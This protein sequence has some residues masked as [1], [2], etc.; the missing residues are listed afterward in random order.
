MCE[1]LPEFT[2]AI[3]AS[4][5]MRDDMCGNELRK[6]CNNIIIKDMRN[7]NTYKNGVLHS[8]EDEPAS[9]KITCKE[10]YKDGV[11]HRE[12]LPARIT[13]NRIDGRLFEYYYYNGEIHRGDGPAIKEYCISE[14]YYDILHEKKLSIDQI[15][16]HHFN[17]YKEYW[18]INNKK[19]RDDEPAEIHYSADGVELKYIW[20]QNGKKHR[21]DDSPAE[22]HCFPNGN[23]YMLKWYTHGKIHRENDMPSLLIYNSEGMIIKQKYYINNTFHREDTIGEA[24][25]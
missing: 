23:I 8:F 9:N 4:Y 12:D 19:H 18:V 1:F 15:Q 21:S 17:L 24:N 7:G 16:K 25:E 2:R 11:L 13:L 5:L 22:V 3:V 10:W 20:Y 6:H 14:E